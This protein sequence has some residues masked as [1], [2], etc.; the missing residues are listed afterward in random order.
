MN[1]LIQNVYA[2]GGYSFSVSQLDAIKQLH[3]P[4]AAGLETRVK[5]EENRNEMDWQIF[6][7]Y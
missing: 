3:Y 4:E 5:D 2:P 7:D 6:V 1:I